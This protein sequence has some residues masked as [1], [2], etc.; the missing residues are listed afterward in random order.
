MSAVAGDL[1]GRLPPSIIGHRDAKLVTHDHGIHADV[2]GTIGA[3]YRMLNG[4][5]GGL[6][7][8]QH[9]V[10]RVLGTDA[11]QCQPMP[12]PVADNGQVRRVR[13]QRQVKRHRGVAVEQCRKGMGARG[14]AQRRDDA[15]EGLARVRGRAL[16]EQG[17][18]PLRAAGAEQHRVAR[19]QPGGDRRVG[20]GVE[21]PRS[22]VRSGEDRGDVAEAAVEQGRGAGV[23][24]GAQCRAVG[25]EDLQCRRRV[26]SVAKGLPDRRRGPVCLR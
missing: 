10:G 19:R 23:D 5:G 18:G 16:V 25:V 7:D 11:G 9:C 22:G 15:V 12:H 13:R 8:G 6:A 17:P 24:H 21:H 26:R 1:R 4:V 3:Q 2:D 20:G 14:C